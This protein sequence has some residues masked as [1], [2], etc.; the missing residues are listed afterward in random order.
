V[1]AAVNALCAQVRG[2]AA[3]LVEAFGVPD[4]ALGDALA[5]AEAAEPVPA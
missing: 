2:D 1:T 4:Q 5:V 3:L